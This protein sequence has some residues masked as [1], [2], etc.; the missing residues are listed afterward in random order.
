MWMEITFTGRNVRTIIRIGTELSS[1]V[2]IYVGRLRTLVNTGRGATYMVKVD[3]ISISDR[4]YV[5][6]TTVSIDV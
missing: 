3:F 5:D 2:H 6:V 1:F 4:Y